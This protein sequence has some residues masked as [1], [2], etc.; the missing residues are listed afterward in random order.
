MGYQIPSAN[1]VY[2]SKLYV[3][4]AS[5]GLMP[6]YMLAKVKTLLS[7]SVLKYMLVRPHTLSNGW[8]V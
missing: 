1:S 5:N 3:P 7:L 4:G 8:S 2:W 6:M